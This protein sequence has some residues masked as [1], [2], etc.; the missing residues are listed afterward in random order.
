[1]RGERLTAKALGPFFDLLEESHHR[2]DTQAAD[3]SCRGVGPAR[4]FN[5]EWK[6]RTQ[7]IYTSSLT[8]PW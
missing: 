6:T 1:M 5:L 7:P 2:R 8:S 3:Q 4:R